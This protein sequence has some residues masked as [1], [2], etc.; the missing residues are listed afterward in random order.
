[1]AGMECPE[2]FE[3]TQAT[4]GQAVSD[5]L[6]RPAYRRDRVCINE[7][8]RLYLIRLR[9]VEVY[10]PLQDRAV[11]LEQSKRFPGKPPRT[12]PL[13]DEPIPGVNA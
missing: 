3:L 12:A 1:M 8:C 10:A 2:C 4:R 7:T 6:D 11:V 5:T 9:T 13:P